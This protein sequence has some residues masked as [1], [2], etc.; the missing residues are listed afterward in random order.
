MMGKEFTNEE[1]AAIMS[2]RA[3][4]F[5]DGLTKEKYDIALNMA[6]WKDEQYLEN[7]EDDA[8]SYV[9]GVAKA[10]PDLS[11]W[12]LNFMETAYIAGRNKIK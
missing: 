10:N 3:L 8:K 5:R 2:G 12:V 11:E 9:D 4:G 7:V 6:Q 1:Q